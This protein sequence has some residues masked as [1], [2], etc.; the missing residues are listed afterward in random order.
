MCSKDVFSHDL[1]KNALNVWEFGDSVINVIAE[2]KIIHNDHIIKIRIFPGATVG[3]MMYHILPIICE[4]AT[5]CTL[6]IGTNSSRTSVSQ[7]EALR[8]LSII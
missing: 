6:N 4:K 3:D 7:A 5:T 1:I 8:N 2:G